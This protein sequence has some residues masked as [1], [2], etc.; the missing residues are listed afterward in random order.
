MIDPDRLNPPIC[1]EWTLQELIIFAICVAGKQAHRTAQLVNKLIEQGVGHTPFERI[2]YLQAK[3]WL[4]NALLTLKFGQYDRIYKALTSVVKL[5]VSDLSIDKLEACP[6]I[7]PKT[8][9]LIMLYHKPELE[10]VP[11]DTHVL[12]FLRRIGYNAPRTTPP[13]GKRYN[14][15]EEGFCAEAR[16]RGVSVVALDQDIWRSSRRA[17]PVRSASD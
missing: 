1:D 12:G 16:R 10:C 2:K 17:S 5:D 4:Y 6:G 9:R 14:E 13:K 15:L 7:G 3:N 8:A 11:L